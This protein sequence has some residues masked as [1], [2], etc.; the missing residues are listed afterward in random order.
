M[1]TLPQRPSSQPG[2][3]LGYRVLGFDKKTGDRLEMLRVRP[4][5]SGQA[6]FETAL[7]ERLRRLAEFRNPAF[8]RVRQIDRL[9]GQ[10]AGIA[11]VSNH[12]EGVRLGD[13]MGVAE[14]YGVRI[15]IDTTL[16][17]IRQLVSA[18]AG[19]HTCG[20][21][22]SHGCIGPERLL[23]TPDARLVVTEYVLGGAL[24]AM[25]WTR[26]RFWQE[27]R[28]ALPAGS[29][30][31]SFDQQGDVM[32]IGLLAL[33]L[34]EGRGVYSERNYPLPLA[35]RVKGAK[36]IPVSGNT[37]PLKPSFTNWLN[38]ALQI[39]A[40]P[41]RSL[42]EALV[43]LDLVIGEGYL[44][45]PSMVTAF[46]DRCRQVSPELRPKDEGPA[47][48]EA[49]MTLSRAQVDQALAG[50]DKPKTG[51]LKAVP[52]PAAP[53]APPAA[54]APPAKPATPAAPP[55]AAAPPAPAKPAT[56][57][58]AAPPAAAKTST[59][60]PA[61]KTDGKA[62][63]KP[64]DAKS[65]AKKP[66]SE[67][68]PA[69]GGSF[70]GSDTT[71][72]D[73]SSSD[74]VGAAPS[75]GKGM[76]FAAIGV[77]A[78]LGLGGFAVV[79]FGGGG[80]GAAAANEPAVAPASQGTLVIDATPRAATVFIDDVARGTTPLKIELVPGQH[81]VKLDGGDNIT[82]TFPVTVTAGKEVSHMVELSRNVDTGSLDIRTEPAGAKVTLDGRAVGNSPVTL[83][84]IP[85][86]DHLIVVEGQAGTARQTV[87]VIAGTRSSIVIP[88]ATTPASPAAGWL[89]V[90]SEFELQVLQDGSQIGTSRTEKLMMAAGTYNLEFSN[91]ALGFSVTKSVKVTPGQV[92]RVSVPIPDGTLSVNATPWAEVFVDGNRIGDTPIGNVALKAGQH[93]LIFRNP[94]NGEKKQTVVV[95]PGQSARVTIDMTK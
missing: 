92:T 48:G 17:L 8:A 42:D 59:P 80:K 66:S 38:K 91:D 44:A 20:V 57:A 24:E 31:A 87:K 22:I 37:Q 46:V 67:R 39:D 73:D 85:P 58:P 61:A 33:A 64:A 16:C 90:A 28:I 9:T 10:A 14:S 83:A 15:D 13:V 86:G 52:K 26:E 74:L 5:F 27:F 19:L 6:A 77:V 62:D 60:A 4:Q 53:A 84:D 23:L 36:E 63:A 30:P 55:A 43:S 94:K 50:G 47:P 32:Q 51:E 2:D 41:F 95:R 54:A 89:S 71:M 76:L 34:L 3:G 75:K 18:V 81:T 88:L 29:D 21:D 70:L 72:V 82:R 49:T 1:S 35:D 45:A 7:R 93:E 68:T 56:P 25:Q 40:S 79:K 65:D 11:I 12:M 69:V 78:V